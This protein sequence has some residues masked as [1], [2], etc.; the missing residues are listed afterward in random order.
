MGDFCCALS[1]N[2]NIVCVNHL[3]FQC[4]FVA[5]ILPGFSN[6]HK[7]PCNLSTTKTLLPDTNSLCE[8]AF[9]AHLINNTRITV[10]PTYIKTLKN[11]K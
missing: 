6:P 7:T 1:C 3:Q 10:Y 5:P 2:F 9:T 4:D 8:W 11:I